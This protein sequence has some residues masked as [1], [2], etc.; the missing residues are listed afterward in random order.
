MLV[1]D[2]VFPAMGR[3][4]LRVRGARTV[5]ELLDTYRGDT[6]EQRWLSSGLD[7]APRTWVEHFGGCPKGE[8]ATV[9][10]GMNALLQARVLRPSYSWL[11]ESGRRV[12]VRDFL[13]AA[14]GP[15]LVDLRAL[16]SY[17]DATVREQLDAEAG[18]ARVMIR[19]GKRIDELNGDDLLHY[20]D[21]VK[22][23]GRHRREHLLWELL[24]QLGPLAD[25]AP[26][27]RAAWSAGGNTRQHSTAMLVDRYGLPKSGVRDLLVGY[28][29]EVRPGMDYGSLEGLAYRLARLFWW[30]VLNVNPAQ[31]DLRLTPATATAWRE[32]LAVTT[33]GRPRR[34]IHSTLFAV[35]GMY[36]DL[37]EWSHDDP[38]RWGVWVA[39]SP[40]SRGLSREVSKETRRRRSR[41][42]DRTRMLTPLLPRVVAAA[43]EHKRLTTL[44]H[45]RAAAAQHGEPFD[46]DGVAFVRD[47]PPPMT[48]RT[49][50][51]RIWARPTDASAGPSWIRGSHRRIDVTAAEQDGF[52]GWAVVETLRHTG[53]RI[54]ELLELTQL[55]L[56]HYTS[57]TTAT[58]VPLLHIV[59]SKTDAE[60]LI[61]MTPELVDV[62][63][64]VQRR[65][66]AGHDHIPLS[67]RYDIYEKVHGQPFPHLFARPVG[68]RQEVLS[69]H[70]VRC[71]LNHLATVAG[72]TDAGQPT[73]FTP[74]DFRRLFATDAVHNG[75]PLH[76]AA[77]ILG[78]L[79]LDTT[80]IY[81]AVFPDDLIT[82]HQAFTERRRQLR[83]EREKRSASDQEWA[84][85][86]EHFL[87]RRVALGDCRRPY[88][89]PCVH[90]HACIRCRFLHLDPAEGGRIEEM[91]RNA[92]ARL[93]EAKQRVWL[94]EVAA[95]EE[96]LKHLRERQAQLDQH[97]T[98]IR[99]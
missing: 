6:W 49:E 94:G 56:R 51:A 42:H 63:L 25:E 67:V 95:L 29:D 45:E 21:V 78:H 12:S 84:D 14:G 72:L 71:L 73:R 54:E 96:N 70:Y 47:S 91:T 83:P 10:R 46:V 22:T 50:R 93:V 27:L 5:L 76:I 65:A 37:A 26:T 55:S 62:L 75:L 36:R 57:E 31:A 82:A 98:P 24:R 92:E 88:G 35:R 43:V 89:T 86:E 66:K 74:H 97:P 20:A 59:P 44:L 39:P 80:S 87:L 18:L 3:Q 28:L 90:E 81:T 13:R 30:E 64:A 41:M 77:A 52:W 1:A 85:F 38:V 48:A 99:G 33:D 23:S 79:S 53:V 16:K 68:T 69:A 60:R 8:I 2:L 11:L 40:V 61:P 15:A 34:E 17:Q 9:Q 32:R 58:V 7:A 19:T 4:A